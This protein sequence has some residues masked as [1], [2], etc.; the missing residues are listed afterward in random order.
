MEL[1]FHSKLNIGVFL[2]TAIIIAGILIWAKTFVFDAVP[3]RDCR[4]MRRF[5][6]KYN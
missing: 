1:Y 2:I 4:Q 6:R 5:L 3:E